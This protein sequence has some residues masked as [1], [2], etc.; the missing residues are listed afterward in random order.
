[1]PLPI[2]H[3]VCSDGDVDRCGS[4]TKP[5]PHP[6]AAPLGDIHCRR[7]FPNNVSIAD[8]APA[9]N[10]REG[11]GVLASTVALGGG[12]SHPYGP[13]PVPW[14]AGRPGRTRV[15]VISG[16]TSVRCWGGLMLQTPGIRCPGSGHRHIYGAGG[17]PGAGPRCR[18]P[19]HRARGSTGSTRRPERD[20]GS[21][22]N[23]QAKP[24][25]AWSATWRAGRC[26]RKEAPWPR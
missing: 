12:H 15:P 25:G 14:S 24:P 18:A 22:T 19:G 11:L 23:M 4:T 16:P 7:S 5:S 10:G 8:I 9:G 26:H 6:V 2:G 17:V 3:Y 20:R 21:S 13:W 1:M